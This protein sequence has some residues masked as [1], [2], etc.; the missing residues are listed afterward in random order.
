M[1]SRRAFVLMMLAQALMLGAAAA[2]GLM[3]GGIPRW[4]AAS[5]GVIAVALPLGVVI[6][7]NSTN[8]VAELVWLAWVLAASVTLAVRPP[9]P[10]PDPTRV[11]PAEPASAEA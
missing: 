7:G 8:F 4:L 1:L 11:R 6:A 10:S 5:A 3:H 9:S 2:S